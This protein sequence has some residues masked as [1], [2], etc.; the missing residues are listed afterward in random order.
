M[1]NDNVP[2]QAE[3]ERGTRNVF[4]DLTPH[5]LSSHEL[6]F[7]P[8]HSVLS[9]FIAVGIL[10]LFVGYGI[11][12]VFSPECFSKPFLRDRA[13]IQI[14]GALFAGFAIYLIYV[15]IRG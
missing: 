14:A 2:A 1:K 7:M 15:L 5:I 8:E 12:H 3:L 6:V 11:A 9:E 10:L 4:Y 13:N